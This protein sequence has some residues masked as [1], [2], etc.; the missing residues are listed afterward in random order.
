[1]V[2][3]RVIRLEEGYRQEESNQ[4]GGGLQTGG[5]IELEPIGGG[6]LDW[7]R[8]EGYGIGGGYWIRRRVMNWRR[9]TG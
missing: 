7:R 5:V 3:R 6:L 9:V 2:W 1:M 8:E 4:F